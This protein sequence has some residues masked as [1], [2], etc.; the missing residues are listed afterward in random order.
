MT[1]PSISQTKPSDYEATRTILVHGIMTS[2]KWQKTA[3]EV[4][5]DQRIP[6]KIYDFGKYG[7]HKYLFKG[8]NDR[9]V[10]EFYRDYGAILRE[11][12]G[13]L[14]VR[15]Y[16]KRPSVVAHSFGTYLVG[17]SMLKYEEVRFDKIIFC[18]SVLPTDFD[19]A[20]LFRR[21]Q[22]NRVKN[23]YSAKDFWGGVT[24]KVVSKTGLGGVKG[25]H[26]YLADFEEK[27]YEFHRHSD[28]FDCQHIQNS[29]VPFLRKKPSPFSIKHGREFSDIK[30]FNDTLDYTAANID[31]ESYGKLPH[32]PEVDIPRGL[33]AE[34]IEVCPD[35]YTFLMDRDSG[36]A[37]GY[38]N[39]MPVTDSTFQKIKEGH[40]K[41]NEIEAEKV[42]PIAPGSSL[43]VYLMSVA[44]SRAARNI[45]QGLFNE[46]FQKLIN[47]LL[48]KLIHYAE[49]QN[50]RLSEVV[51]VGWTT[52]GRKLCEML[53]MKEIAKDPFG[54]PV[55]WAEFTVK[56]MRSK[57][58]I[59]PGLRKLLDL[60]EKLP[61]T[62]RLP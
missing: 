52:E 62:E 56:N 50:V 58:R 25:F 9:K 17:Y 35:I 44:I 39:A 61:L 45:G 49:S 30:A 41:D 5:S 29:W 2:A 24:G 46:A 32:F 59:L 6:F 22:V 47:G 51:G 48:D 36:L 37:V 33:S 43:K 16:T 13:E 23:E 42:Q 54:N 1:Q 11:Y 3:S 21:G 31:S 12:G 26:V 15:S 60:Y 18:G 34:W 40:V 28:Y 7:L 27:A 19:W 55:Y 4:L 20:T 8:V 53:G 38:I 14:D 57:E 10:E